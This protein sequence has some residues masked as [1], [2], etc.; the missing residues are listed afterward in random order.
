MN[1]HL[2]TLHKSPTVSIVNFQCEEEPHSVSLP[3]YSGGF[4]INFTRKGA[5]SYRIENTWHDI[6]TH[7]ILLENKGSTYT[8]AHPHGCGDVCTI[9]EPQE[10]LLEDAQAFFWCKDRYPLRQGA[11]LGYTLF[12]VN[13]L[14]SSPSLDY[15]HSY[16]L[17][18]VRKLPVGGA[19]L[20]VDVLTAQL[21]TET[22]R[23]LYKNGDSPV[24]T[25][26]DNKLKQ[27]HLETIEQAK[28]YITGKFD[29]DISLSQ[30]ATHVAVSEFHFSRLFK[31]ITD[32]SPYQYLLEVRLHH[33]L[34]L[35][36]NT[37]LS[38][39]EIC[40]ASGF[41]SFPHFIATFTRRYGV[42]PL[43]ARTISS[44]HIS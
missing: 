34:L 32:C 15:L 27:R 7:T 9:I 24:V 4:S 3:E 22:F 8:V 41:N 38:V 21:V 5:F 17:R 12:P 10:K 31:Q 44:R 11:H 26:L 36:R 28:A 6:H 33:A 18:A 1:A 2:S 14:P 35:L 40:F 39:S 23:T 19:T 13:V 25:P 37:S 16:L 42:S 43:K 30:I 20:N 29:M